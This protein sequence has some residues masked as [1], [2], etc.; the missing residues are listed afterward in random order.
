MPVDRFPEYNFYQD[1]YGNPRPRGKAWDIGVHEYDNGENTSKGDCTFQQ[2]IVKIFPNP[3]LKTLS[4][5]YKEE[6]KVQLYKSTG[7]LVYE[8]NNKKI[9][10][11][12]YNRGTY[13]IKINS[14][15]GSCTRKVIKL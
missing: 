1:L 7:E 3:I 10:F 12:S 8:N 2:E 11:T 9:D 14:A 6:C 15:K 4:I 5:D 13:I